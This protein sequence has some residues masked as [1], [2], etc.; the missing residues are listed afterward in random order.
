[1]P[2]GNTTVS[3]VGKF[4]VTHHLMCLDFA[5]A[6]LNFHKGT[7][8]ES[9]FLDTKRLPLGVRDYESLRKWF[10][11]RRIP[12]SR[13]H[14]DY[15]EQNL[16]MSLGELVQKSLGLSLSDAFWVKPVG[17]SLTWAQVNFFKNDFSDD[18]GEYLMD[19]GEIHSLFTPTNTTDG[20]MKKKWVIKNN[21]RYLI[22]Q[23]SHTGMQHLNEVLSARI[24]KQLGLSHVPY[25]HFG[26]NSCA[27]P[28]FVKEGQN[29]V[30]AYDY[31]LHRKVH[32]PDG[33]SNESYYPPLCDV[34]GKQWIDGMLL[35]DYIIMNSDRHLKNL[36]LLQD[37]KTGNLLG[38]A[39]IFDNGNSLAH[40][41]NLLKHMPFE[42]L[43]CIARPFS[44]THDQQI[45][46]I[47]PRPFK[48]QLYLLDSKIQ[49]MVIT[50]YEKADMRNE[51]RDEF[52]DG[53]GI[54]LRTRVRAIIN[55]VVV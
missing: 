28:C 31:L 21:I 47:D 46:L 41:I 36:C 39:P 52:I 18:I 49:D 4:A 42:N 54:L 30:T 48:E 3:T 11:S 26:A 32:V 16:N 22:K 40:G 38:S 55:M 9:R 1:M 5:V 45:L 20:V 51:L 53:L 43:K 2:I 34:F 14:I 19:G 17:E 13:E 10:E 35:L 27:C 37:A 44:K 12:A 23:G 50:V 8:M 29:L 7:I 33:R 24:A 15:L 6:E 25:F